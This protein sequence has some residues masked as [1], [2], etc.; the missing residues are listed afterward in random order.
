MESHRSASKNFSPLVVKR[1]TIL[2]SR[3]GRLAA[4]IGILILLAGVGYE[5]R[6]S[7]YRYPLN[8]ELLYA[9]WDNDL[10]KINEYL[11]RGANVNS[12]TEDL[13]TPLT[14][15]VERGN[16]PAVLLLLQRGANV[17]EL[18][19]GGNSAL[20]WAVYKHRPG[21]AQQLIDAGADVSLHGPHRENRTPLGIAREQGFADMEK[22]LVD[23]GA[24]Y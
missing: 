20:F 14:G 4:L 6:W 22:L 19:G 23:H 8:N 3:W 21:I 10:P 11:D 5:V 1:P 9:A 24:K 18:E 13:W 16:L 2:S 15:A 17:N 7:Y 12:C